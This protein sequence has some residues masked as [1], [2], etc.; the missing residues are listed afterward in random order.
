[1]ISSALAQ[2]AAIRAGAITSAD[3]IDAAA[4]KIAKL[5]PKLNAITWTRFAAAK[6]DA[7]QL[8]DTGQPFLGVPLVLKGLGQ[9]FAGA[10][11]TAGSR[12]FKDAKATSTNNFVKALQALGFV[13]IGQSNV[14]EF[15][16]KNITDATLYGPARNP[17][18]LDYSPGGS[19]GGAAA[20]VAAGISLLAA[21]SDGGGSIRIPASFS[22][23]IGLKPTRGRVQT[24]PGEWRGWQGASINFAL[25]RTMADTEALLRGLA[26]T[27]LAAPF[28]ASPLHLE[29]VNDPR[30]LK[31]AYTTQ[32]PVG[33]PVSATAV[34]AVALVVDALRAA[35]HTV[36]EAQPDVDGT[37]L[38]KAYYLMNG[39]E[40]AA[41]FQAYT[42]QTGRAVTAEDVEPVTWAIY[43]AGLHTTAADYS[44]SLDVWDQAA[45]AYSHFHDSYDLLLT[46]TTAKTAPRID[47]ELQSPAIVDKMKHAAELAPDEQK[48]L[49]WDLFEP[50]L[51]YSPFTQQANLTGAPAISLPTAISPD[52]LPLG[53]QFVAAKG[54][55]DQLLRLGYWFEQHNLL[56]MYPLSESDDISQAE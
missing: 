51:A 47:A 3:L 50:S 14:P 35:G 12:L 9:N 48:Q 1:M 23:L 13:I 15:G 33:T 55:E 46:P 30:P 45:E 52:G 28:N 31:I 54:R 4:D 49:V 44:R 25:T 11:A 34:K 53:I 17:W 20:L 19:S 40:T 7:A 16:F 22:G 26:T 2:A 21:G 24:G 37:A 42:E 10:P 27:Q 43:Q 29:D 32:S 39:G 8:K 41:M 36:V 18:N 5:N 38:M 6:H 56:Q